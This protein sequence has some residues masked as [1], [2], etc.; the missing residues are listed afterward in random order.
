MTKGSVHDSIIKCEW[1]M[2]DEPELQFEGN[3]NLN[4]KS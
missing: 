3:A 4:L 1:Q 2:G